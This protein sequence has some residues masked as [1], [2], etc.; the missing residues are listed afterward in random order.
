MKIV[1]L[2]SSL[3]AGGAERVASTLCNAWAA[4]GDQVTLI[5]TF[6]GGGQPFYK[7]S[8]AVETIRL[9]DV[10]GSARKSLM[11]SLRR[12]FALRKLIADRR[13]DVIVSFLPNV[14]VA[15]I[16]ASARLRIPVIIC[17]RTDPSSCPMPLSLRSACWLTYRYADLV[18]VQ[19]S[20]VASSIHRVYPALRRV[21]AIPNPLPPEIATV[22][23]TT[24]IGKRKTLLSLGRLSVEKQVNLI[25]DAFASV[26]PDFEDW[27]LHIYGD[28]PLKNDLEKQ[29]RD[30]GMAGRVFLKG[31][32]VEPWK[33]TADADLFVMTSRFEG[34]PNAML[35]AMGIGLPCVVFDCPSGPREIS[36]DGEDA[37]LVKPDDRGDLVEALAELMGDEGLRARLGSRARTAV[38][39][40]FS[41]ESVLDGWDGAFR[42][43]GVVS[44][45]SPQKDTKEKVH[46]H[47]CV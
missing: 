15:A 10:V 42:E 13:P 8:D 11:S 16:L 5:P 22:R 39:S 36:D 7:V 41:A 44:C 12:L 38:M 1:L 2:V 33:I 32:T 45:A 14:N 3:G 18:I 46:E 47:A 34:F 21:D 19:T 29:I 25:I 6:S 28:G 27:D 4:R 43:A 37:R 17:E 23:R 30:L 35:E 9:A 24:A 26:A 31:Q 40:R 20:A